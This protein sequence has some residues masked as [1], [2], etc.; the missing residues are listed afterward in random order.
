MNRSRKTN[1]PEQLQLFPESELDHLRKKRILQIL[2]TELAAPVDIALTRN[3][4]VV[5]YSRK[6]NGK[7]QIRMHQLFLHADRRI[8][9]AL[10][11]L[12]NKGSKPARIIINNYLKSHRRR[13]ESD[14]TRRTLILNPK[15]KVY[16][17]QKILKEIAPKY[18]LSARGLRITWSDARIRRG[19]QSIRL[20][21]YNHEEKLI[22]VHS[23]LDDESVPLYF[24]KYIVYHE[25]LHAL[26]PPEGGRG[27]RNFHPGEYHQLEKKFEHYQAARR[28]EKH[29][30]SHWLH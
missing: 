26:I 27:R 18:G 20:G 10:A 7:F 19:Q 8:I 14:K 15:G 21:S 25:L 12:I 28:F 5:L 3:R 11:E 1:N 13:I 22:R 23:S 9:S 17:L 24:V 29:I 4:S 30:T 6:K 2:E 16:D